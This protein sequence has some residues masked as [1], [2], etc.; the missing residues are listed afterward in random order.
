MLAQRDHETEL[1]QYKQR[2]AQLEAELAHARHMNTSKPNTITNHRGLP[3]NEHGASNGDPTHQTSFPEIDDLQTSIENLNLG[4][5]RDQQSQQ[6]RPFFAPSLPQ[7]FQSYLPSRPLSTELVNFSI[8]Q[9]SWIHCALQA[10]IFLHQH[11]QF[12]EAIENGDCTVF[13]EHS[14]LANY[15]AVLAVSA[16]PE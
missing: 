15:Y 8:S 4:I 2:I 11:E 16:H 9:L 10:S 13:A 3:R 7:P 14:W 5:T 1:S 12:W 6:T